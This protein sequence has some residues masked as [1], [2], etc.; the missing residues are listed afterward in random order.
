MQPRLCVYTHFSLSVR[1]QRNVSASLCMQE[2]RSNGDVIEIS[3]CHHRQPSRYQVGHRCMAMMQRHR[4]MARARMQKQDVLRVSKVL[5]LVKSLDLDHRDTSFDHSRCRLV[6]TGLADAISN[7]ST[8]GASMSRTLGASQ[9][10]LEELALARCRG[11]GACSHVCTPCSPLP[12]AST[13]AF[14]FP[15]P[16]TSHTHTYTHANTFRNKP[17]LRLR[18]RERFPERGG[19]RGREGVGALEERAA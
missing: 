2:S 8:L 17:R 3:S 14:V 15:P 11:P 10:V 18:R 19:E 12:E 1:S 9:F 6:S 13:P 5:L 4:C 16:C 7:V